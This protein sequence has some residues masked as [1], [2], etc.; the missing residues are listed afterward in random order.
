RGGA[1]LLA[2]LCQRIIDA[3]HFVSASIRYSNPNFAIAADFLSAIVHDKFVS[4]DKVWDVIQHLGS[5]KL[6]R[7]GLDDLER[8]FQRFR[9]EK[10]EKEGGS[11]CALR[12]P[13]VTHFEPHIL[14]AN[15]N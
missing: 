12:L 1:V 15:G 8:I 6:N 4:I 5:H 13:L 3:L 14:T 7:L 9:V 11:V 2:G 10:G